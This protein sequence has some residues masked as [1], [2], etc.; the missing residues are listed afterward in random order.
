MARAAMV[1]G[2]TNEELESFGRATCR[3][4][5][6]STVIHQIAL[7]PD[8]IHAGLRSAGLTVAREIPM[9]GPNPV[10]GRRLILA[11]NQRLSLRTPG[12]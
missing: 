9:T 5:T 8:Q 2:A 7:E 12:D 3:I 11:R 10:R 1:G 6:P 4:E